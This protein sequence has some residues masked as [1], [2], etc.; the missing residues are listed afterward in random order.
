MEKT[1]R[2][3]FRN[4]GI[5]L[6]KLSPRETAERIRA[7]DLTP[8]LTDGLELWIGTLGHLMSL[9]EMLRPFPEVMKWVDA[10]YEADPDPFAASVRKL[11]YARAPSR[12]EV[13]KLMESIEFSEVRPRTLAW[14]AS[15]AF[16]TND[17]ELVNDIFRRAVLEYPD[18]F[19][20]NFDYAYHLTP[21]GEW[22]KAIRYYER[23][24][25]I[26]PNSAGIWRSL[27]VALRNI[28]DYP[29]SIDALQRSLKF[30]PDHA[31]TYIDLGL[32]HEANEDLAAAREAYESALK[33]Q[34]D[35]EPALE[36]L[37][38]ISD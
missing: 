17:R 32:T 34:A 25:A 33:L 8:Q 9:G 15:A 28:K 16:R 30:Q 36:A 22:E 3:A 2:E 37:K 19:M 7:S 5:D 6:D 20:L 27:G 35:F 26:R 10:L 11:V 4:Y 29:A 31:W 38:R 23:C 1:L 24:L 12:D 13:V 14:L 21:L 18:D